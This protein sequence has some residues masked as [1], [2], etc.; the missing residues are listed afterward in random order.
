VNSPKIPHGDNFGG[1][2]LKSAM[3]Q[4]RIAWRFGSNVRSANFSEL[5]GPAICTRPVMAITK[6]RI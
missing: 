5:A 1:I 4:I 2:H 6:C 3:Q